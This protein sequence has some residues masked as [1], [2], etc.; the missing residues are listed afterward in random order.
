MCWH[1]I[2]WYKKLPALIFYC[3]MVYLA[4]L[5]GNPD[6]S[7]WRIL[8]QVEMWLRLK[9]KP[10]KRH[11][12]LSQMMNLVELLLL[13][14]NKCVDIPYYKESNYN[15]CFLSN[16][17]QRFTYKLYKFVRLSN[18]PSGKSAIA[19]E[20][21]SLWK[22]TI[23]LTKPENVRKVHFVIKLHTNVEAFRTLLIPSMLT[24]I[25]TEKKT[26]Q[27]PLA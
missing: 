24:D 4:S 6:F 8:L 2:T 11:H 15:I 7:S 18:I 19:F 17:A 14:T 21:K 10:C 5:T 1:L 25:D 12:S 26:T 22:S 27:I 13:F 23:H 9:T 20:D 16:N 3:A